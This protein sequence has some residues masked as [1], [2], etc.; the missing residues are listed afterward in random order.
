MVETELERLV[1]RLTGDAGD[2]SGVLESAL[3]DA[4][5]FASQIE[6]QIRESAQQARM[7]EETARHMGAVTT[8]ALEEYAHGVMAVDA[9]FEEGLISALEYVQ[10]NEKLDKALQ[11]IALAEIAARQAIEQENQ[12]LS[13]AK[14]IIDSVVTAEDRHA[15]T[16]DELR[17]LLDNGRIS[18]H[19]YNKALEQSLATLPEVQ[20]AQ[21]AEN[22][23][24]QRAQQIVDSTRTAQ[25]RYRQSLMDLGLAL[26]KGEIDQKEFN[27]AVNK[28][29]FDKTTAGLEQMAQSITGVGF[30]LAAL[31]A[32][33][34]APLVIMGN[35]AVNASSNLGESINAVNVT[36][37]E[38]SDTV[39]Q[40]GMDADQA[41]GLS[42]RAFNEAATTTGALLQNLAGLSAEETANEFNSLAQRASDM[43][44]V[45]NTDVSDAMHAV[46]SALRGETEAIRRYG[47]SL[48]ESVIKSKAMEMGIYATGKELTREQK[49]LAALALIYEQTDRVAG[50]FANTSHELANATRVQQAAYENMM[51]SIG[52]DLIPIKMQLLQMTT[53]VMGAFQ[54]LSPETQGLAI[55]FGVFAAGVGI[56]TGALGT[57]LI[58]VGQAITAYVQIAK[59]LQA[60]AAAQWLYNYAVL[61]SPMAL[62]AVGTVAAVAGVYALARGMSESA[63]E[64]SGFNRSME[65]AGSLSD[66]VLSALNRRFVS[67][68]D[69]LKGMSEE[70]RQVTLD[71]E[72]DKARERAVELNSKVVEV[73]GSL[74]EANTI[75]NLMWNTA[76]LEA[77]ELELSTVQAQSQQANDQLQELRDMKAGK[78]DDS[79]LGSMNEEMQ[80][81]IVGLEQQLGL[82]G[83]NASEMERLK[84]AAKLDEIKATPEE[85]QQVMDLFDQTKAVQAAESVEAITDSFDQQRE[86][87]RMNK[88][89]LEQLQ[90]AMQLD[91]IDASSEDRGKAIDALDKLQA[92]RAEEELSQAIKSTNDGLTDQFMQLAKGADEYKLWKLQMEG[93][94]E[95]QLDLVR[96]GMELVKVQEEHNKSMERGKQMME[97]FLLPTEKLQKQID[98]LANLKGVGAI[99]ERTFNRA[100]A[101]VEKDLKDIQD[102]AEIDIKFDYGSIADPRSMEGLLAIEKQIAAFSDMEIDPQIKVEADRAK[103]MREDLVRKRES[104]SGASESDTSFADFVPTPIGLDSARSTPTELPS[105]DIKD[106]NFEEKNSEK[107]AGLLKELIEVT[108][109]NKTEVKSAGLF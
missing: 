69:N 28:I 83:E 57:S 7:M 44:S 60:S 72:I 80:K 45:F 36:F 63:K 88:D 54:S 6:S 2:Y 58:V 61:A 81:L 108:K 96:G 37:G 24:V 55:K 34:S 48:D 27:A 84:I 19:T 70:A 46:S 42:R 101:V 95:A 38:A 102:K 39:M 105:I 90:L 76:D 25:D 66:D 15:D 30:R 50:D 33:I 74:S 23:A 41:M 85:R 5:N 20:A 106:F 109:A 3:T 73:A 75:W 40:Y 67:L 22:Q 49:T 32:A 94:T 100:M 52:D 43:A 26:D 13:R 71:E 17:M 31:G 18:Q 4:G 86:S 59:V 87:I 97:Q 78:A 16:V 29:Q 92:A 14:Q 51:A 1:V 21:Q 68:K 47:V 103:E 99:D 10:G 35:Q 9:A 56:T 64:T 104:V 107:Q 11:D 62:L 53:S 8:V 91:D 93:A 98:D 77:A 89:E 82:I 12:E 79:V 65:Q